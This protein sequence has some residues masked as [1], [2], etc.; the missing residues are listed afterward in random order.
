MAT[1]DEKMGVSAVEAHSDSSNA[2]DTHP[3]HR[4]ATGDVDEAIIENLQHTGEVVGMTWRTKMAVAVSS[5]RWPLDVHMTDNR[6]Q[7]MTF[8]YSSY[9]F[10]L[11][12]PPALLSY[13]NA[14]LGPDPRYTWITTS[15]NLGGAIFVTLGGRLSDIF[16]RRY[17]FL[18]GAG[19]LVIGAIVSAT[20]QSIGQMIAGGAL[21]GCGSGFLEMSFGAVQVS[22]SKRSYCWRY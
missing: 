5:N 11:L 4:I 19:F 20:G 13:L 7:S 9:L 15:W 14:E 21:F 17:F 16:G 22:N 6:D 3:V 10:T 1:M 18:A 2:G 8:A 12:I